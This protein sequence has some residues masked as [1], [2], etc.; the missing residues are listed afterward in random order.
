MSNHWA[1]EYVD[2]CAREGILNGS[3]SG[4]KMV[5]RP[6]APMTR[7][8]FSAALMRFLKI[9]LKAYE[10]KP[11]PF[12]DADKIAPWA[13]GAVGAAYSLGI[14]KGSSRNGAVY[15]DP[16]DPITRQEA[17]TILGRTQPKGYT[18]DDLASFTDAGRIAPWARD[19]VAS[20]V[21]R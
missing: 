2:Y 1:R 5:F 13:R 21:S 19:Y 4:N 6:E 18:P 16:T 8:E 10:G 17:M 9:N 14:L 20:M 11:L 15:A 7:Q 3:K 12:A